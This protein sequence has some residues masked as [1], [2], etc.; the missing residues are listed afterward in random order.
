MSNCREAAH[1][2]AVASDELAIPEHVYLPDPLR[3]VELAAAARNTKAAG[4]SG[5]PLSRTSFLVMVVPRANDK[6]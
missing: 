6:G 4:S 2:K 5:V 1:P 3:K